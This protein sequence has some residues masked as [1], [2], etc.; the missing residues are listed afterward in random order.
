[1]AR[2]LDALP[3]KARSHRSSAGPAG[4]K[5]DLLTRRIA[6]RD[7]V[8]AQAEPT[9]LP[10]FLPLLTSGLLEPLES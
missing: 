7:E 8:P 6:V 3:S 2:W 5:P 4:A 1:M 10:S 9:Q